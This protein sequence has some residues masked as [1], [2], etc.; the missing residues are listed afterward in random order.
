MCFSSKATL[1]VAKQA[2][3]TTSN[4]HDTEFGGAI[5]HMDTTIPTQCNF[6]TSRDEDIELLPYCFLQVKDFIINLPNLPIP[7]NSYSDSANKDGNF[8]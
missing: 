8:L 1:T 2:T 7:F 6:E 5:Y 3:I 4:N